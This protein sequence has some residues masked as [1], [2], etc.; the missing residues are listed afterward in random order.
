[1][2]IPFSDMFITSPFEGLQEHAEKVKEC[3]WAFQQAIECHFSPKCTTFEEFRDE[4]VRLEKEADAIKRRIRGH[5]PKRTM[6]PVSTFLIFRYLKQQD[7]VL[8]A[9]EDTLDWIS[10]RRKTKI[11]EALEKD[12]ALLVN[13]V[14]DPI[15]KLTSMVS[16]ARQYFKSYSEEQRVVVKNI[17][18]T[19]HRQE[20][21]VDKFE[22]DIKKKLFNLDIDAVSIMYLVRLAEIIGSIAD[23]AQ[24]AGDMMRAM[25]S[26]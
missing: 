7:G 20:R 14:I 16:E 6:T 18:H 12:F 17:I 13:A 9:M 21:E 23:H 19:L 15:E 26:K 10:Y 5:I 11:P 2:R 24:N 8:D 25:L 4:I 22:Y 3:S 1:M